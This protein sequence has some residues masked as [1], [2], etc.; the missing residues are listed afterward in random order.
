[1]FNIEAMTYV[2]DLIVILTFCTDDSQILTK[3]PII[4]EHIAIAKDVFLE[5]K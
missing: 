1:M 3:T 5:I 2:E 4:K